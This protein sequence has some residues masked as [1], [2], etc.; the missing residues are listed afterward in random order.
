[1]NKLPRQQFPNY[2]GDGIY[3]M[4][5]VAIARNNWKTICLATALGFMAAAL[6]V[7]ITP[8]QYEA[9]SQIQMGKVITIYNLNP[10]NVEEPNA[11]T[12]RMNSSGS[13]S[14][15][16]MDSCGIANA[17]ELQ[18]ILG[19][20]IKW[21]LAKGI[22]NAVELRVRDKKPDLALK[23]FSSIFD[24]IQTDQQKQA[25]LYSAK[26]EAR[27]IES[28]AILDARLKMVNQIDKSG[29]GITS[30]YILT[31]DQI[32]I[33]MEVMRV[34]RNIISFNKDNPPKLIAP[35][36]AGNEPVIP[37]KKIA[38]LIGTFA[39]LLIGLMLSLL[40][41]GLLKHAS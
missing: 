40:R 36:N 13:Y 5:I 30:A 1:M 7:L 31:L 39:G 26:A 27:L 18:E 41:A 12:A 19:K 34:D 11:F 22:L 35:I 2:S 3:L 8:K 23:C 21:T 38:L 29:S 32:R 37:K 14:P 16:Q 17:I 25:E 9:A 20:K 24:L 33:Y 6:Y 15:A 28:Q 10:V 4:D